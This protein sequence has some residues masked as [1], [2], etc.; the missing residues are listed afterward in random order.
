MIS[1]M[2]TRSIYTLSL[3]SFGGL[4]F[5]SSCSNTCEEYKKVACENRNSQLCHEAMQKIPD[6]SSLECSEKVM[7]LN[8]DTKSKE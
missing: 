3:L 4:F 7:S 8:Q 5:V 2:F 1:T 6:M